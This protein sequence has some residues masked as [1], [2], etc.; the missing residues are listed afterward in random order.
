[1]VKTASSKILEKILQDNPFPPERKAL[2]VTE[3]PE[4]DLAVTSAPDPTDD[5]E[6]TLSR[7]ALIRQLI[8]NPNLAAAEMCRRSFFYF[9]QYFWECVSR[10]EPTWNWHIEYLCREL[11]ILA[12]R[13]AAGLPREY[14][15]IVN[16]PPGT[17]KSITCS[18]MFQAWCWSRWPWFKFITASYSGDLSLD[19][20]A[21]CR[22]LV[23]SERYHELFPHIGVRE[24]KDTK[25]NFEIQEFLP[26]GQTRIGGGRVSTSVGGTVT[27]YHSHFLIVDDPLNPKQAV[28]EIELEKANYF[29]DHTLPTRKV[30]KALTPTILIMQRLHQNDPTGHWLAKEKAN[31]KHICLPGEIRN[32]KEQAQPPEVTKYYH[33]DLLDPNRMSW[34]VLDDLLADLGQYGFAGQIGQHPVPPGGGMFKVDHFQV[35]D[36]AP[37]PADFISVVR[38]WDK[39]GT[40]DGGAFTVGTK[41]GQLKGNKKYIVLDVRRGQWS[42]EIRERMMRETAEADGSKVVIW[43]E[44]EPASGGKESAEASIKNL[45]GFSVYADRPT[46]DKVKRADPYSVQVNVG[47]ILLLK[48]D[49]N[50]GF[51]EE[52]R[53]FPFGTFKDQVDSAAAGF[54]QLAKKKLAGVLGG[55]RRR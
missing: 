41:I 14:D 25:S 45:A 53:Y 28:S 22:D 35:I 13:V 51:I 54:N 32:Y 19:H 18:I 8:L 20:A 10:E 1:M 4:I 7:E 55:G 40:A 52:H 37:H 48:G 27:G 23:K 9:E 47:N 50:R 30:D 49:W 12:L 17:T 31:V 43:V 33:N 16:V 29:M 6:V 2:H 39:A 26:T 36:A 3:D 34:T 44:Q 11:Q 5:S 21:K 46:G 24:D 42:A 38:Y 15:L